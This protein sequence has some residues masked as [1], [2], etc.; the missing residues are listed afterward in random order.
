M[1]G[2]PDFVGEVAGSRLPSLVRA[3]VIP[4]KYPQFQPS[5]SRA[6]NRLELSAVIELLGLRSIR[7]ACHP[8]RD[9]V[10]N[11]AMDRTV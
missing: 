8:T 3:P 7:H 4:V 5:F 11:Y 6:V 1:L 10:N 2:A 9:F